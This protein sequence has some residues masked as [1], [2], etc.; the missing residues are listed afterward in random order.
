MRWR[1]VTE[2]KE[3]LLKSAK[4]KR[5]RFIDR[6]GHS[7]RADNSP[8]VFYKLYWVSRWWRSENML[9]LLYSI[10]LVRAYSKDVFIHSTLVTV[11][12]PL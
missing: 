2:S 5:R 11:C 9:T 7:R 10:Q 8:I 3:S 12:K 1:D 6:P 4:R